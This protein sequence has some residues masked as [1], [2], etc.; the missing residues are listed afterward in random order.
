MAEKEKKANGV[1]GKYK[2]YLGAFYKVN[3][4]YRLIAEGKFT[5]SVHVIEPGIS[6]HPFL[7]AK[8]IILADGVANT[9]KLSN[10]ECR[11]ADGNEIYVDLQWNEYVI[12]PMK[13]YKGSQNPG[14][15]LNGILSQG[16]KA[17][18]NTKNYAELSSYSFD[19]NSTEPSIVALKTKLE[20]FKNRCGI[21]VGNIT[22]PDVK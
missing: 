20:D 9:C 21:E 15:E 1:E 5:S 11:S 7:T 14:E 12:D 13:L 8:K 10:F 17:F 22:I 6:Y 18:I 19:L 2:L 3:A 4:K 16:F